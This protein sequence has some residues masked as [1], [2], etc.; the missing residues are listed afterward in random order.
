MFLALLSQEV[1]DFVVVGVNGLVGTWQV[2]EE[3][4][5][6]VVQ[7]GKSHTSKGDEHGNVDQV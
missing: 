2:V 1:R 4:R 5:E 6:G 3:P 7:L